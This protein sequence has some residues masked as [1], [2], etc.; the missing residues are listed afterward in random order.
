MNNSLFFQS[1]MLK[2]IYF[3]GES[4]SYWLYLILTITHTDC[5]MAGLFFHSMFSK[6]LS[7]CVRTDLPPVLTRQRGGGDGGGWWV[8]ARV[9]G[10]ATTDGVS[11]GVRSTVCYCEWLSRHATQSLVHCQLTS[12]WSRPEGD[13]WIPPRLDPFPATSPPPHRPDQAFCCFPR[14]WPGNVEGG[15]KKCTHKL[16]QNSQAQRTHK[17]CKFRF[18]F[19]SGKREPRHGVCMERG[20]GSP[21]ALCVLCCQLP[22]PQAH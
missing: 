4:W 1:K 19:V 11:Q 20:W 12:R 5:T 9:R 3:S 14:V 18:V 2:I 6:R 7:C 10:G 17:E 8:H 16:K 21:S 22:G 15:R 13:A